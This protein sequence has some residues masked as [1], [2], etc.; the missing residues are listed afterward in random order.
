MATLRITRKKYEK[1]RQVVEAAREQMKTIKH[2]EEA[3][4]QIDASENVDAIAIGDDGTIRFELLHHAG[5][6][7]AK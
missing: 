5:N 6:G 3:V 4:K 1:A 2:W 7:E